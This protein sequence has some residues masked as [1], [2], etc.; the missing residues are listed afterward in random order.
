VQS[1]PELRKWPV[2]G[3]RGGAVGRKGQILKARLGLGSSALAAATIATLVL[4]SALAGASSSSLNSPSPC[5]ANA[6]RGICIAQVSDAYTRSSITLG[7]IVGK[8]TD[9]TTDPNWNNDGETFMGWR[10]FTNPTSPVETFD[11]VIFDVAS[12]SG[13]PTLIG[14]IGPAGQST[15]TCSGQSDGVT[16]SFSIASNSYGIS[17]PASC[18][19]SPS[20]LEVSAQ[21]DYDN[22]GSPLIVDEPAD[23]SGCCLVTSGATPATTTTTGTSTATT[24]ATGSTTTTTLPTGATDTFTSSTVGLSGITPTFSV[25]G[26]WTLS[27]IYG[28]CP[29]GAPGTFIVTVRDG[30]GNGTQDIGLDE[31]G[32]GASGVDR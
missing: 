32:P 2:A 16:A 9:P 25:R 7:A 19:H 28:S 23:G 13:P 11:A 17:F 3:H 29:T 14:A 21:W 26:P 20:S 15:A 5:N 31:S 24:T 8:A 12:A 27:W 4:V 1:D 30:S 6:S 18:I 10:V 22:N